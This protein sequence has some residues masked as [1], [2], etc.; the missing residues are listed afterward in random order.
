EWALAIRDQCLEQSVPFFFKQWGGVH[1]KKAGRLLEGQVWDE[2]PSAR[3]R[4]VAR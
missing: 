4:T 3:V 2:Y 1:K